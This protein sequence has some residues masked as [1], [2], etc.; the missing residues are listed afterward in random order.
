M[1]IQLK[2]ILVLLVLTFSFTLSSCLQNEKYSTGLEYELSEDGSY[3]MV[4]GIGTCTDNDIVI[5]S[6][7][8]GLDVKEIKDHSFGFNDNIYSIVILEGVETIGAAAFKACINLKSVTLPSTLL[9]IESEAFSNCIHLKEISLPKNLE[10][11]GSNAFGFNMSL[12]KIV[13][14][15]SVIEIGSNAFINDQFCTIYCEV[16]SVPSTWDSKWNEYEVSV[17]WGYTE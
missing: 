14:P 12:E 10:K 1:K 13:I 5:P 7:Y 11:I 6:T 17:V 2:I 9:A 4:S 3:Y 16:E 8:N 15:L